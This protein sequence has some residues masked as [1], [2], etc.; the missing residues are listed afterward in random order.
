MNEKIIIEQTL[1][2]YDGGHRLLAASK[3]FSEAEL[4]KMALMSDF[5]SNN[6]TE[7]FD[8]Y[9][10][11]YRL[12]EDELV[13]ACTWY[14]DEMKRPGC[15]W[16]QSLVFSIADLNSSTNFFNVYDVFERP[17]VG[18][19]FSSYQKSLELLMDYQIVLNRDKLKY[20]CWKIW[21]DMY[22][23]YIFADESHYYEKELIYLFLTQNDLLDYNF[24]F[25]TLTA[26]MGVSLDKI[27]RMQFIPTDNDSLNITTKRVRQADI[28]KYPVW[29]NRL[30]GCIR[31]GQI[32][33]FKDFVMVFAKTYKTQSN[34]PAL[35]KLYL[36]TNAE[37]KLLNLNNLLR[38]SY[39]IFKEK[40]IC[41]YVIEKY[42]MHGFDKWRGAED[43][44]GALSFIL[45]LDENYTSS[46]LISY[47][48]SG[49]IRFQYDDAKVLYNT[50]VIKSRLVET[51]SYYFAQYLT[52]DDLGVFTEWDCHSCVHL[53]RNNVSLALC[54]ELWCQSGLLQ[55]M[56]ID[57]IPKNSDPFLL[58]KIIGKIIYMSKEN[59]SK[60]LYEVFGTLCFL[61]FWVYTFENINQAKNLDIQMV[62]KED[63][64]G[65]SK[66]IIDYL[67][68]REKLLSIL[69]I[70]DPYTLDTSNLNERKIIQVYNTIIKKPCNAHEEWILA[71]FVMVMSLRI[72]WLV[73]LYLIR[74]SYEKIRTLI[75]ENGMEDN[76]RYSLQCLL[77]KTTAAN[78]DNFLNLLRSALQNKGYNMQWT[79]RKKRQGYLKHQN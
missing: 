38:L 23:I 30:Y 42:Q 37:N 53:I 34:I 43:Y 72:E 28:K 13:L 39:T 62:L 73:P 32:D 10:V 65:G 59:L 35:L 70:V 50:V 12:N 67:N 1:H 4:A 27:I 3:S 74:F 76:E 69:N 45:K 52:A 75:K 25:C 61:P 36:G 66:L 19:G 78:E 44:V 17:E 11:G 54:D 68:D 6:M 60:Y 71:R 55:K 7:Q 8:Y 49:A 9:F 26:R 58:Q 18:V 41:L 64:I 48:T 63:H 20:L 24:S 46:E 5:A 14:A 21:E 51:V 79:N 77:E 31:T 40:D 56:I 16:T 29:V 2:G 33:D 22:P 57:N 15:V 47:L